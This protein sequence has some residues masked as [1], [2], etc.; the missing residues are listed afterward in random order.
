[1]L[2][3]SCQVGVSFFHGSLKLRR[4]ALGLSVGK[5]FVRLAASLSG[6]FFIIAHVC[7]MSFTIH[8]MQTDVQ[9]YTVIVM[10]LYT[11]V[12]VLVCVCVHDVLCITMYLFLLLR[13]GLL[14]KAC[15]PCMGQLQ[16]TAGLYALDPGV[17]HCRGQF[18]AL[19]CQA[20]GQLTFR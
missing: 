11:P 9:S 5:N 1:M 17:P 3:I 2:C 4:I 19:R 7:H 12:H 10:Y 16:G 14:C 15:V 8:N 6:G 13:V 20:M 18:V